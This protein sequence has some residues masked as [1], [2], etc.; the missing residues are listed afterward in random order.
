MYPPHNYQTIRTPSV[1]EFLRR[2]NLFTYVIV[3]LLRKNKQ[4]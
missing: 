3:L 1:A 4:M 2:M